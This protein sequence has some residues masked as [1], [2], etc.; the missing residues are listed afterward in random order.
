MHAGDTLSADSMDR[1]RAIVREFDE[2]LS[3]GM[4]TSSN[5]EIGLTS[6]SRYPFRMSSFAFCGYRHNCDQ[7][8]KKFLIK[9][10]ELSFMLIE[11]SGP[12]LREHR[13]FHC[14]P[15]PNLHFWM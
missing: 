12:I 13:R 9:I 10:L 8:N 1:V 5:G 15:R 3:A 2:H 7:T 6:N 11:V 4:A 14:R